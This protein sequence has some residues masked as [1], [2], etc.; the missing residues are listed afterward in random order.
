MSPDDWKGFSIKEDPKSAIGMVHKFATPAVLICS[1]VDEEV[2]DQMTDR[3]MK[4]LEGEK[5]TILQVPIRKIVVKSGNKGN[6]D[7]IVFN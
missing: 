1:V 6:K 4:E 2:V 5:F 3:I 7:K